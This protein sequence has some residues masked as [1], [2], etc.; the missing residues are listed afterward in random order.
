LVAFWRG[1]HPTHHA[2]LGPK[3]GVTAG[4]IEAISR[5]GHVETWPPL[6]R[7][8]VTATDELLDE[9]RIADGTWQRLTENLDARQ[10]V[11][12]PMIVGTYTCLAMAFNSGG[13]RSSRT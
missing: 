5:G 11:E 1:K 12:V 2:L 9:Y 10:L 7:D 6:E 3:Y 13:W 8:L 4:D